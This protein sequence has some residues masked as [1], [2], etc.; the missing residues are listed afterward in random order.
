MQTLARLFGRSPF[1]PLQTHMVKV[2]NCVK[3]ILS[4]FEALADGDFAQIEALEEQISELEHE[5]D[6]AKND[7]RNNLPSGLFLPI[8]RAAL[9]EIL[10]LQDSIADKVE[11][12]AKLLTIRKLE[13][14]PFF[15][16]E[17]TPFLLKNYE[18]FQGVAKIVQEMDSLLE[19][20]FGGREADK[21]R[22]WVEDVAFK[23]H[24]ADL[25]QHALLKKL[26]NE[27]ES[28][29]FPV[30]YLWMKVVGEVGGVADLAEK[31]ANRIRMT[32]E[33]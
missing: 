23:E 24:E 31:L 9:L 3:E 13:I 30:F 4:L 27:G 7:I 14:L 8:T 21:V 26:F 17:F 25:L 15:K 18:A 20:S 11:N 5:A 19:S 6:L 12:T 28:L 22:K 16:D 33:G 2:A 32:L 29:P 1:A 10:T